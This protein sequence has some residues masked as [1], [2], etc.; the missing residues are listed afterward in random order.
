[1]WLEFRRVLFRS[2]QLIVSDKDFGIAAAPEQARHEVTIIHYAVF[3]FQFR[4]SCLITNVKNCHRGTETQSKKTILIDNDFDSLCL[5]GQ[6]F[7][8]APATRSFNV[9]H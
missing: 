1:M 9:A 5:C 3:E 7:S 6:S 2:V 4:H 8:S